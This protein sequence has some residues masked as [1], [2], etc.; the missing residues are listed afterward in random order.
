MTRRSSGRLQA[1]A[2]HGSTHTDKIAKVK[3]Q[4]NRKK[5]QNKR[6]NAETQTPQAQ[7]VGCSGD[8]AQEVVCRGDVDMEAPVKV[9]Q[10][11]F[12][13][14]TS[15]QC[16]RPSPFPQLSWGRSEDVW[17]KMVSKE[18]KYTHSK[19]CM[20]RHPR[21][22]PKMRAVLLDWLMEVCEAYVLHRQTF[23][24]A[25][26]FF[27]R[28]IL[29]QDDVEKERLQ[30]IGITALFI[31][32]KIEEIYP[33][34]IMELAY[35]TDGAC[36]EEEILQMELV[37]LKALNWNLCPETVVS[38]MKLYV[39]MASVYDFTNL[40]V[41]Q[42]S[43]ETY[44]RITQLLDLCILDI[45]SLDFEYGVLAASACCHYISFDI[46]Q[47]VSGLTREAVE[48][49]V[50]WM[51]PFAATIINHESVKLKDFA[52]V[53]SDDRHNI[54]THAN[55]LIMLQEVEDRRMDDL[56]PLDVY[57]LTPPS[58]TEKSSTP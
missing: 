33:P 46:V 40:L 9:M 27:D 13:Q 7:E 17:I 23:Y 51:A 42:F 15:F 48:D 1:K 50:E 39:Q 55:H 44:I 21:L 49:C 11:S 47:K 53:S 25:Q 36:L 29:T 32:S 20:D 16:S 2:Q 3:K 12:D 28:F 4:C 24:L 18:V 45:N 31:A 35:V 6:L 8:I 22:Q 37:M 57:P 26:D 43:Q 58:S 5:T 10:D 38:W 56:F 30:L 34:K 54:Q 52:K 19:S 14:S 41:P